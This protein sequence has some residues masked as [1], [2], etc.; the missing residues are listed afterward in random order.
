MRPL[1]CDFHLS[2][3]DS[4][5]VWS[6]LAC[7]VPFDIFGALYSEFFWHWILELYSLSFWNHFGQRKSGL[8]SRFTLFRH[9]CIIV[10]C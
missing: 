7:F 9:Y 4:L 1:F 3:F 6:P 8:L 10:I 2:R 5:Y